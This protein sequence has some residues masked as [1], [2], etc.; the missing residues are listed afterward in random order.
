[1][2]DSPTHALPSYLDAEHLGPWGIYLQQVD[3]VTPYLGPP[4]R[5]EETL[6]RPKRSL[7]VDSPIELA[8]GS[9]A[10]FDEYRVQHNTSR[11]PGQDGVRRT[12]HGTT[13][14]AKALEA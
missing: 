8:N 7:I 3:R 13:S 9:D 5:W 4:A 14:E 6:K 1:M 12:Q 2:S 10:H 11:G